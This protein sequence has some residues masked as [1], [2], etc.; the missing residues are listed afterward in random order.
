M[1]GQQP[2]AA[3]AELG[4]AGPG[5]AGLRSF[6]LPARCRRSPAS[7]RPS[8]PATRR[9]SRGPP[10]LAAPTSPSGP[11]SDSIWPVA[12]MQAV[13]IAASKLVET[14]SRDPLGMSFTLLTISSPSPG[15]TSLPSTLAEAL[16]RALQA[17]RH[18]P[19]GD[20]GGLQSPR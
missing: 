15:P 16:A 14:A 20:H 4:V 17:R 19:R 9:E 8:R 10:R 7:R 5:R 18:N 3:D 13:M 12:R 2:A 6:S 11:S 1:V